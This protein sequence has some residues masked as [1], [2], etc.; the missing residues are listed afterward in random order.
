MV[1]P[2]LS[3]VVAVPYGSVAS[4]PAGSVPGAPQVIG[5]ELQ[6]PEP[7]VPFVPGRRKRYQRPVLA[8]GASAAVENV[9]AGPWFCADAVVV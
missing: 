1:P 9:F 4:R 8:A 6:K 2:S 7:P 5:G 3:R